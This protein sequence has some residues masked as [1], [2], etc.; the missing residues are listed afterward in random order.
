[1]QNIPTWAKPWFLTPCI[2]I[3]IKPGY[4]NFYYGFMVL[5]SNEASLTA[6]FWAFPVFGTVR[7]FYTLAQCT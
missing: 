2:E 3:C 7:D 6:I 5:C 4:I 1:M